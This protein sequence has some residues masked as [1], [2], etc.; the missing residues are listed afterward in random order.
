MPSLAAAVSIFFAFWSL[1]IGADLIQHDA[2][3]SPHTVLYATAANITIDCQSRYSVLL[4][5]SSPGPTLYLKEGETTWI[6]VYNH[7]PDHN[8][9]VHWHGLSARVAPYSDGSPQA[10]QWPIGPEHFFDYEIHPEK[11]EAGTY[12]YHSHIGFQEITAEGPLI[13]NSCDPV[14]YEYDEDNILNLQDYY[15]KTDD[16]IEAGLLANPFVWSGETNAILLNGQSGKA[17]SD[18]AIDKS[19]LPHVIEVEPDRT[20]RLRLIGLQVISLVTLGIESHDNLT[21]IEADGSFTKKAS[22]DHLQI[23]PGQRFSVLFKTK[24]AKEL[25]QLNST[26]FWIQYEN[27]DRPANVSG[28]A[29]LSYRISGRAPYSANATSIILPDTKPI[30]LPKEV[31]NWL[32]YTLTPFDTTSNPF[33]LSSSVTRTIV[34]KVEQKVNGTTQWSQNGNI[35]KEANISYPYLTEIYKR[36]QAAIPRLRSRDQQ[37]WMGSED[38]RISCQAR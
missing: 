36:G 8:L 23:A 14:P 21:I 22:T 13:V 15:N 9:T 17:Q 4:N 20:Y 31:T 25:K 11:G 7:I 5:G 27:R 28:F 18:K 34:I 3:W 12:F 32:E 2:S 10:S 24:S 37:L 19:C 29:L 1:P 35:W 26:S 30:T 38:P 6:R 33:P 16:T